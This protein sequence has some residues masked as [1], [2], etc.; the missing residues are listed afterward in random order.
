MSCIPQGIRTTEGLCCAGRVPPGRQQLADTLTL[1]KLGFISGTNPAPNQLLS[2]L[3]F[4]IP[5]ASSPRS[6]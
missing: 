4:D 1:S 6:I 3:G 2:S 5:R